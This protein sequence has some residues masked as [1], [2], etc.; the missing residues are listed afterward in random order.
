MKVKKIWSLKS[1][2]CKIIRDVR[3]E[4]CGNIIPIIS[5]VYMAFVIHCYRIFRLLLRCKL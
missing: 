3:S 2:T 5:T 1:S 4:I